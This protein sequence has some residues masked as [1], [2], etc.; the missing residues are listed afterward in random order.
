MPE[1]RTSGDGDRGFGLVHVLTGRGRGKTTSA[2]GLALRAWGAGARVA[3]IQ[4][5]KSRRDTGEA[6]AASELGERFRFLVLGAGFVRG[7]PDEE[8]RESASNA[9]AEAEKIVRSGDF[10][11]VVADEI[12]VVLKLGL[13]GRGDIERLVESA[14]G[15]VE[16]VLTGRD[17]PP[18]LTDLADYWTDMRD[19]KHPHSEGTRA[20]RGVEF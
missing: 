17:A 13:L 9:L 2:L 4:F 16:L 10:D 7:E 1:A 8:D 19:V 3:F 11:L 15:K 12:L 18:W 14:R 20:R 5:V 6:R